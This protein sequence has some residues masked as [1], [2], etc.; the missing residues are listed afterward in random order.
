M[1][2]GKGGMKIAKAAATLVVVPLLGTL[3]AIV[4]GAFAIPPDPKF[5]ASGGHGSPGDGVLIVG[6]AALG[7]VV[8]ILLSLYLAWTVLRKPRSAGL[9]S[10]Q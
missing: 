8:S 2:E 5:A 1:G 9:K 6:C 7:L 4:I 3:L 10:E